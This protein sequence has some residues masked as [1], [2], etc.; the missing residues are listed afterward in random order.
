MERQ[1]DT[2]YRYGPLERRGWLFGV[3]GGQFALVVLGLG[4]SVLLVNLSRGWWGAFAAAA[5]VLV[6][7]G[8]A[9]LPLE[10]RGVDEWTAVA[11]GFAWR[12]V[13]GRERWRSAYPLLG[14]VSDQEQ[15]AVVAPPTLRDVEILEVPLIGD[16][17]GVVC[18][19]RHGTYSCLLYV[20]AGGFL[21]ADDG[22]RQRRLD[23]YGSALASLCR[24]GSPVSRV[25]WLERA[26]PD[27][28][29][30]P[31]RQLVEESAMPLI[32]GV[33]ESYR[34]LL[35][36]GRPLHTEHEV[37]MLLQVSMAR[38]GRLIR[39]AGGEDEGACRVLMDEANGLGVQLH[40]ADITVDGL[41][42]PRGLAGQL[43]LGFEPAARR[44]MRWRATVEPDADGVDEAG[45]YPLTT[46]ERWG[47]YRTDGVHHA[48][49][50]VREMPRQQVGPAWMHALMLETGSERTVSWVG[51]P[52]P[53]RQAHQRVVR[54]QVED[55]ATEDFKGRR[56]FVVTRR[57]QAEHANVERREAELVAGHGLFRY[58][59][60]ITV[61]GAS[62]EELEERCL[63]LEQGSARSML[64]LQRLVGQ[65]ANAFTFTLPL[66]RGL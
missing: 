22:E 32:S 29:D 58:N 14:F 48:T 5:W 31:A 36:T 17:A 10:G 55:I 19:R 20:H 2:G 16:S 64:E 53:P 9:V 40:R 47:S 4:G 52:L 33:V 56:G 12:R 7:L 8:L 18:D 34:A 3:R 35:D 38:A 66:G 50:W 37:V 51:E 49:Y 59:I 28:G 1:E 11:V 15:T 26:L 30:E 42:T 21:L 46:E 44:S 41:A 45:A 13:L 57:E 62:A 27:A 60:Y 65:Q 23:A 39:R 6:W 43:R 61:S 54:Q 25:Q 63:R 24:E